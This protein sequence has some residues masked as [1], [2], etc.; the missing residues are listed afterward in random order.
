MFNYFASMNVFM[1]IFI[2]ERIEK[3]I[4]KYNGLLSVVE[5]PSYRLFQNTTSG[6]L[7]LFFQHSLLHLAPAVPQTF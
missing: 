5:I 1:V 2:I 7:H 4:V 3:N 6:N